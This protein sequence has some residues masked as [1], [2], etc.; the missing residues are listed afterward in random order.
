MLNG[1]PEEVFLMKT[2]KVTPW[3]A[4]EWVTV[5]QFDGT[6]PIMWPDGT[7]AVGSNRYRIRLFRIT[8][9]N[10]E[11]AMAPSDER[12]KIVFEVVAHQVK[13]I[14]E[15]RASNVRFIKVH[16]EQ[17]SAMRDMEKAIKIFA[18]LPWYKRAW[19][20]IRKGHH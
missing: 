10:E 16:Q 1:H 17:E 19:Q 12:A 5:H 8:N 11:I 13:L 14:D 15:L 20:V 6:C 18:N 7:L 9:N 3:R 2:D 4:D